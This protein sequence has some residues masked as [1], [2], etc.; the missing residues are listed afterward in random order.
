MKHLVFIVFVFM[1]LLSCNVNDLYHAV[2]EYAFVVR[3]A[4]LAMAVVN[5]T[6]TI[7]WGALQQLQLRYHVD[8][9]GPTSD[10]LEASAKVRAAYK[11]LQRQIASEHQV[12][13]EALSLSRALE[14]LETE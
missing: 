8:V 6:D 13:S 4:D 7:D 5:G 3:L 11:E 12:T 1:T 10:F 9:V 2:D 14:D